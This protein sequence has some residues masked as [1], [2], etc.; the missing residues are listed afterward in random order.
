MKQGKQ[1]L[2]LPPNAIAEY[3]R[4]LVLLGYPNTR[5]KESKKQE[6]WD[7]SRLVLQRGTFVS[8]I[9]QEEKEKNK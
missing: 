7:Q 3:R 2:L 4:K 6:Q 5:D 8:P 1:S 9:L